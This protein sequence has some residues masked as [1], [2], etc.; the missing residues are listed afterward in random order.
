MPPVWISRTSC[1]MSTTVCRRPS[2]LLTSVCGG[3]ALT[4]SVEVM[5]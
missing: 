2:R 1:M 3:A 4:P 5:I